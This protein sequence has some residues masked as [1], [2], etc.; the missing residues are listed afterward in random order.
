MKVLL[1]ELRQALGRRYV[2]ERT[3]DLLVY[4]YD[5]S[6]ERAAPQLVAVPANTEQVSAVV[7]I[8]RRHGVSVTPRGAGTGLSG[9][10]VPAR[11]GILMLPLLGLFVFILFFTQFIGEH[12][13]AVLFEHHAFLLPV[14][15]WL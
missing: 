3:E 12:G 1:K 9:G 5:G 4:E 8:A 10:A 2:L 6:V 7:S 11:G 13:K 14:P 15:F